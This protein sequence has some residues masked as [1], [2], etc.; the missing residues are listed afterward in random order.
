MRTLP[1]S[2]QGTER[3]FR[4]PRASTRFTPLPICRNQ[5]S[6]FAP[7]TTE[8]WQSQVRSG[9]RLTSSPIPHFHASGSFGQLRMVSIMSCTT[10]EAAE[11]TAFTFWLRLSRRETRRRETYGVVSEVSS[12]ITHNFS[13]HC[14]VGSCTTVWI[15]HIER[16]NKVGR[17]KRHSISPLISILF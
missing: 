14:R 8:D 13:M 6:L 1:S 15:M 9:R 10:S 3:L 7:T 11:G 17:A 12:K 2:R 4:I 5:L 16:S